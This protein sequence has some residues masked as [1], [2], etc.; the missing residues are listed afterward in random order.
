MRLKKWLVVIGCIA[1][2]SAYSGLVY[3]HGGHIETAGTEAEE[4]ALQVTVNGA[5]AE[6]E[7]SISS[8][9][10]ELYVPARS[11]A[12][13]L[14]AQVNWD[15]EHQAVLI[16]TQTFPGMSE[17]HG[18]HHQDLRTSH[19]SVVFEN[20]VV[21]T[22]LEPLMMNGTLMVSARTIESIF[23]ATVKFNTAAHK[24]EIT[25]PDAAKQ[26]QEEEA[27]VR[28][29]LNG[30]GMAPHIAADGAKEFTLTAELHAWSPLSGV[31]TTAWTYNGQVPG[32]V[33]RVTEGDH[34]RITLVNKLPEPTTIH[35]HGMQLPNA[36]D[37][38]PG[39]TQKSVAPGQSFV[40]DFVAGHPGTYMYHSHY[41]DMKQIGNGM[42]GALIVDP[43]QPDAG[44]QYDHDYTMM[45]SGFQ[46]NA[47]DEEKD[48]F[49]INGRSYPDTPSIEVKK[50]DKVR[51]RLINID[52][53]DVHTMHLHGMDFQVVE[54]DGHPV[55][56]PQTM[57]TV[58]IGPGESYD[59]AFTA[60]NPGTWMLH[61]HIL[62]HTMNG[63]E[64]SHGE[65]GGLIT[66][67]KVSE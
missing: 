23:P 10:S 37:G 59:I 21:T 15:A 30:K 11:V 64:M 56:Q 57:N 25:T 36:M 33:I 18:M 4:G 63:G 65:M 13:A 3:A 61:C 41:D 20:R 7:A 12:E 60:D 38:V 47:A 42:Y 16:N 35:W 45:I 49:T 58:L 8:D 31:L 28:D 19:I 9:L 46:I 1:V 66:L 52:T 40:Y 48:Y 6:G 44:P 14:G 67:V 27:A 39:L 22:D 2:I 5:L 62:D 43:K 26:F 32:P 53:T 29:A 51:I 17:D 34:L 55:P 24:V 50:G 54:K